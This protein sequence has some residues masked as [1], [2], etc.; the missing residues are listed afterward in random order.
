[1]ASTLR[2]KKR[3]ASGAAGAPSSLAS[4][5]LAFNENDKKLYYGFGDNGSAVASSIITVGGNGAFCDLTTAQTVAGAKTFSD[6]V[7]V[8]GNLTV[9]GTTTTLS[10]TNSVIKDALIELG[11]GT[12]GT[13]A[14]DAGLVIEIGSSDNAFIGWDES[15][16]K[17][18]VGTGSFVGSD[19]GNL[20][21]TT[22]TL[23]AN[24][25]G[26]VTGNTSGSA[27]SCTGNSATAT[28]LATG[29]T[30]G[31]TG[32]VVWTSASFDGSGNVTGSA[33]IQTGAVEH[34][35]LAGDCI[36]AD[37][38]SDDVI[39][40]EHYAAG[41]VDATALASN[42]VTSVKINGDA[43]TGAKIA[44][45]AIDSEHITDGSVDFAHLSF[46]VDEDDM[47]SDSAVKIPTQQSVKAYV[48][49]NASTNATTVTATANNTT[50]ETT[51]ITFVDGATGSQGIETD[52]GLTYNPSSGLL[53][54][55]VIDGGTY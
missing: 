29:R 21:I 10:T 33:T 54:V 51:Y 52:T 4:S 53:T 25:E 2:I 48:D 16:D 37:N 30:V 35:M 12:S 45:D 50:D 23:V 55:G 14:N 11:N 34:A 47:S 13:P 32:D 17:F 9:N 41:S 8:S 15:A 1:M 6:N 38:I 49:T 39:G 26:N 40:T 5:E 24:L 44:D 7:V 31:M 46:I 18:T 36:D 28:A 19:T 3:A 22:G 43:V 42:A 27:G 20:T